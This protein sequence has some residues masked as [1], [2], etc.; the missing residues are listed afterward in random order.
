[1]TDS[2]GEDL[3]LNPGVEQG[4]DSTTEGG[5]CE[6]AKIIH[7][8]RVFDQGKKALPWGEALANF[9]NETLGD[10]TWI[11]DRAL[12][13]AVTID[14]GAAALWHSE[15]R[16]TQ[17]QMQSWSQECSRGHTASSLEAKSGALEVEP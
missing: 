14:S 5:G 17:S 2:G 15:F 1:M 6:L 8:K 4:A 11:L 10:C 7:G 9:S 3:T 12:G 13:V 16:F